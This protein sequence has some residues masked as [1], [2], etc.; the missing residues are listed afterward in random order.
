[1]LVLWVVIIL[2]LSICIGR[3]IT[4]LYS[5]KDGKVIHKHY[6]EMWKAG[7]FWCSILILLINTVFMIFY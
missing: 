5:T 3:C 1:M 7:I 6:R 4:M 2:A